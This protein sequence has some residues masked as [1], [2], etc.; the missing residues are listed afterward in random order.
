M[1]KI[2]YLNNEWK[3]K[4]LKGI[5]TVTNAVKWTLWPKWQN[6]ILDQKFSYP[7]ITNDGV[8]IA[9]EIELEDPTEEIG[10]KL[11]KQAAI[12]TNDE[13]GD[14]TST[15]TVF[16]EAIITE[17]LK[18]IEAG[19]SPILLKNNI[20]NISNKAIEIIKRNVVP[21]T[22]EEEIINVATISSQDENIGKIIAEITDKVWESG[23]VT[24]EEMA[25]V[26]IKTELVEGL[27]ID[28]GYFSLDFVTDRKRLEAV[29]KNSKV[30]ITDDT[31]TSVEEMASILQAPFKAN[32][33][34]VVIIASTVEKGAL[35]TALKNH[36]EGNISV[37]IIKAPWYGDRKI[38]MLKDIATIT[39]GK[40]V[41]KQ[42][43][44]D[45]KKVTMEDFGE[46]ETIKAY[47][48]YSV[49]IGGKGNKEDLEKRKEEIQSLIEQ[50]TSDFERDKYAQRLSLLNGGVG[51]IKV[52]ASSK[53]E[54]DEIKYRIEDALNATKAAIEEG[55][56]P[57]GGTSYLKILNEL[58]QYKNGDINND[59]AV[60][61][62]QNA[63]KYPC[64]TIAENAGKDGG[65]IVGK[66]MEKYEDFNYGYN[67]KT[68]V[69]EDLMESG[70]IDPF[71]VIRLALQN[72]TSVA[73]IFLTTNTIVTDITDV[74]K[75]KS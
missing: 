7:K 3:Q 61:I 57:W 69:F 22:K 41:S 55:I 8:T 17:W 68:D 62:I 39:G 18:A 33:K 35:Y 1:A 49:I 30:F 23:V 42:F 45:L 12:K 51:I 25:E 5:F 24:T 40:V 6:V 27:K 15:S 46:A 63:L 19:A 20:I 29:R 21:I 53:I 13:A 56:L 58:D 52:G 72:A 67:A 75:D 43:G 50:T 11:I 10:C 14:W 34:E 37:L 4:V 74:E 36:I 28:N 44:R 66:V 65:Y 73:S 31:I 70:V 71:K 2:V 9:K 59:M 64:K 54:L 32:F 16:A 60:N 38:E 48:N 47:K 26:G